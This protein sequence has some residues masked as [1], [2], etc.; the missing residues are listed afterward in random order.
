MTTAAK[1]VRDE[2]RAREYSKDIYPNQDDLSDVKKARSFLTPL[3]TSFIDA[4]ISNE[5]KRMGIAHAISQAVR[6]KPDISPILFGLGIEMDHIFGSEWLFT[7]LH[8]FVFSISYEEVT[9]FKQ[10]IMQDRQTSHQGSPTVSNTLP[11]MLMSIWQLSMVPGHFTV[12]VS[13]VGRDGSQT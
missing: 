11:T 13:I 9:L 6:P 3:L 2:I 1:L 7:Q 5:L 8:S 10:S 4:L 12:W